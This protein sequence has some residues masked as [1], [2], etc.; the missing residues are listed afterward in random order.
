MLASAEG[1][2]REIITTILVG[3]GFCNLNTLLAPPPIPPTGLLMFRLAAAIAAIALPFTALAQ[4][5]PSAAA[6]PAELAVPGTCYVHAPR[7]S[8]AKRLIDRIELQ[9][10]QYS[11]PDGRAVDGLR[12]HLGIQPKGG[13]DLIPSDVSLPCLT[14]G[15][16]L[17]CTLQCDGPGTKPNRL[18]LYH[19]VPLEYGQHWN[20]RFQQFTGGS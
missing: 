5:P 18:R 6:T 1:V 2:G 4:S 19:H 9:E 15:K 11:T 17:V 12:F 16:T 8:D 20:P 3:H 13:D 14:Q 7:K 10:V